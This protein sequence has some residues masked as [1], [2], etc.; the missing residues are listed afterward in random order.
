MNLLVWL[1]VIVTDDFV[2]TYLCSSAALT[3]ALSAG[4]VSASNQGFLL[5]HS[6]LR[7]DG[8]TKGKNPRPI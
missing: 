1:E 3:R 4:K 7:G 6:W 8:C 2:T 5:I